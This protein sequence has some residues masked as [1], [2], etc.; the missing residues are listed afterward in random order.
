MDGKKRYYILDD[1]GFCVGGQNRSKAQIEKDAELTAKYIKEEKKRLA[2][3]KE[4][5]AHKKEK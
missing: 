5:E 1:I 4:E 3:E 2:L